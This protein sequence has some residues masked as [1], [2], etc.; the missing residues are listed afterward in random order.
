MIGEFE[1]FTEKRKMTDTRHHEQTKHAQMAFAQD[2]KALAGAI[3]DMGNPFGEKGS[4]LLVLDTRDLADTAVIDS[5]NHIEKLGQDQYITYVSEH[6]VSQTKP[7][8][9][10]IQRNNLPLFCWPPVREKSRSQQQFS[11]LQSDCS[12]FSRLFIGSQIRNGNLDEFFEYE[13]Q[14]CPP[15]LSQMGKLRTGTKSDL[16]GCFLA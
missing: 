11:S 13:N 5:L 15:S 3:E 9:D 2:V 16:L 4:D 12:L 14:A 1:S 7:I 10:P 8:T 6:L